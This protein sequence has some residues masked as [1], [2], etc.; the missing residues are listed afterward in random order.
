MGVVSSWRKSLG[1]CRT[2]SAK[3]GVAMSDSS[4]EQVILYTIH[5][6][7]HVSRVGNLTFSRTAKAQTL[8]V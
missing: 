4:L 3:L 1:T 5:Y 8:S 2:L 6:L 7:Y